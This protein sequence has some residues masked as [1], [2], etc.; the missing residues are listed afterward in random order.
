MSEK[1]N[2]KK[3]L[4]LTDTEM[5]MILQ[6][7]LEA[8]NTNTALYDILREA[9]NSTEIPQYKYDRVYRISLLLSEFEKNST[10]HKKPNK[11]VIKV[12]AIDK[13]QLSAAEVM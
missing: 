6:L 11:K 9:N 8:Y 7:I 12:A 5:Q 13:S 3:A 1:I 10:L 4:V 2:L